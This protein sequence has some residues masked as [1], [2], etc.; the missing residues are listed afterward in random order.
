MTKKF[1][2]ACAIALVSGTLLQFGGCWGGGNGILQAFLRSAPTYLLGEFLLDN[3][4]SP[5]GAAADVFADN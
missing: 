4:A 3:D 1:K 5:L 2:R